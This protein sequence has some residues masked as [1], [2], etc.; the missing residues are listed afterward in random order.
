MILQVRVYLPTLYSIFYCYILFFVNSN[1]LL[2]ITHNICVMRLWFARD[3][4]RYRNVFWLIDWL[5]N[6][7]HFRSVSHYMS[8]HQVYLHHGDVFYAHSLTP[9]SSNVH[10]RW[11]KMP[12]MKLQDTKTQDVT[13]IVTGHEHDETER[14]SLESNQALGMRC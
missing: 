4:W 1:C 9:L 5:K 8:S 6:F 12:D 2:R 7:S 10:I 3:I 13:D 14:S 11:L